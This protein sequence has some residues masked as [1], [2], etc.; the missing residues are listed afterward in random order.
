MTEQRPY[1]FAVLRYVR[2]P[3]AG[4]ML[5]VR[6]VLH[7]AAEHRLLVKTRSTF[8]RVKDAFPDLDGDAFKSAMRA[9]ERGIGAVAKELA[10]TALLAGD[11]DAAKLGRAAA[12]KTAIARS[13]GLRPVAGDAK[14]SA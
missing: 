1:T 5:N 6:V 13:V 7:V 10:A 2:D 3:R 11:L 8:G 14:F 4:E 9:V 12:P